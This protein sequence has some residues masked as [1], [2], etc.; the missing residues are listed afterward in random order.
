[1][2]LVPTINERSNIIASVHNGHGHFGQEATWSRLYQH[3]WW[4]TAYDEIKEFVKTCH[5]CQIFANVPNK[6]ALHGNVPVHHLFERFAIDYVGPF[7]ETK[8]K[9][10]Y[11]ILA[12][13]CYSRWPV[14]KAVKQADTNTTVNFMYNEIFTVFGPSRFLLSDNGLHFTG[15]EVEEFIKHIK[16]KHQYATPYHPQT[17]GMVESINGVIVKSL[18]KMAFEHKNDWDVLLPSVLYAYRTKAHSILKIYPYEL[19]FGVE[20]LGV[21]KD[22]LQQYGRKI[23]FERLVLL[24]QRNGHQ[25]FVVDYDESGFDEDSRNKEVSV[26]DKVL[27]LKH[28]RRNKLEPK[29]RKKLYTVL[30]KKANNVLILANDKGIRLK[31]AVNGS[32]VRKYHQRR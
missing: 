7:P 22:V 3:Y 16:V 15:N 27:L 10:R 14:T 21:D 13:E 6:V 23:G 19:V 31:R 17:N 32:Q 8:S 28:S 24:Q 18:K 29:Y 11:I 20:P 26:G 4:P 2:V 9:N 1:M 12:V 25:S 5:E 30:V